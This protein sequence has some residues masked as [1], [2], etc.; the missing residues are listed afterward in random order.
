MI[1]V[2]LSE[3]AKKLKET[4]DI[5]FLPK[6]A[7]DGSNGYDL[8]ACVESK[9]MIPPGEEY[10]IPTGVHVWL[11]DEFPYSGFGNSVNWEIL[12]FVR[13]CGLYL[14][15]SSNKGLTLVNTVG[16]LDSDYQGESFLK[17]RNTT[18]H[19][20]YISPGERIGQLVIVPSITVPLQLVESFDK[21]T[22]R[23]E[24]GFGSTNDPLGR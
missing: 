19:A 24:G 22:T 16:L 1:K 14:P 8:K 18:N 20:I 21:E 2:K 11:G 23:G 12:S 5:D 13:L 7:T 6:L 17:Y 15:R 9:I 10:K 4:L 3:Q